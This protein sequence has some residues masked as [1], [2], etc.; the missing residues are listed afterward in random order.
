M[1]EMKGSAMLIIIILVLIPIL[2]VLFFSTQEE[3]WLY[4]PEI[5]PPGGYRGRISE[6][7][8]YA[9]IYFMMAQAK[10]E[11]ERTRLESLCPLLRYVE[12]YT[13]PSLDY[14]T[15]VGDDGMIPE[16]RE[17]GEKLVEKS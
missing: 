3:G 7:D 6:R 8:Q 11:R 5:L 12:P 10:A 9:H 2:I 15:S 17:Y 13:P 16:E 1:V 4:P 14:V